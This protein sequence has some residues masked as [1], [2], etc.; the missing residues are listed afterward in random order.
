VSSSIATKLTVTTLAGVLLTAGLLV[1]IGSSVGRAALMDEATAALDGIRASRR[2]GIERYFR[3]LRE[4]VRTFARD[5]TLIDATLAFSAA[6]D[7]LASLA[8][9]PEDEISLAAFYQG[10]LK[11]RLNLS[12]QAW[13]GTDHYLPRTRAGRHLQRAYVSDNPEPVRFKAELLAA[14]GGTTYDRLHMRHHPRLRDLIESFGYYDLFLIDADGNLVYSVYK[15]TDFATNL[16]TGPY[17]ESNP[18]RLFRRIMQS[19][20]PGRVFIAD[21]EPYEPSYNQPAAFFGAPLFRNGLVVGAAILQAPAAEI[22]LIMGDAAGLGATGESFLVGSDLLLRSSSRFDREPSILVQ[23]VDTES[24]RRAV[25]G[26]S[27]HL[28]DA[29][30]RGNTVL[31]AYSPVEIEGLDWG[32]VTQIDMD[33]VTA[34]PDA[35]R[36]RLI[37]FGLFAALLV[38]V[39]SSGVLRRVVLEPVRRLAHAARSVE[40]GEYGHRIRR[41]ADDELGQ[42]GRVF[43]S[44]SSSIEQDRARLEDA[45][46]ELSEAR[47]EAECANRAKSAF[48]ANMSHELRTPMNA[49]LGY[50]EMVQEELAELDEIEDTGVLDDLRRVTDA[51]QHLLRLINDIL[52]LSKIE[53][54]RMDLYLER[55]D[56][57]AMIRE[58]ADTVRPLVTANDNELVVELDEDLGV[59]RIDLTKT[60]Q[61]LF[62]LISNAAKFTRGGTVTLTARR[63][64][65]EDADWFSL[66]VT[67]TGIGLAPD[68][69]EHVFDE[70]TQADSSTTRVYGGTGLGLPISRRFC[71]MMGG[72]ITVTSV[73]GEGSTFVIELPAQV[74]ALE[75]AKAAA[76]SPAEPAATTES[77]R[78]TGAATVLVVDDDADARELLRRALAQQGLEVLTAANGDEGL[79]LARERAP[80][81]ITLDVV[82]PGKDGWAV[83]RE[84]KADRTLGRIPVVMVSMVSE[85]G[86]GYMLGAADYLTKPVDKELLSHLIGRHLGGAGGDRVLVIEDD[87]PTRALVRRILEGHG[88][89]ITEAADGAA[90]LAA[91]QADGADLIVLDLMMPRMDGFEFLDRLRALDEGRGVPVVILTAKVL[92]AEEEN[93]LRAG[94]SGI[95]R[96][97]NHDM[98]ELLAAVQGQL[99]TTGRSGPG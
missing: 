77:A 15:E 71:R 35:L 75:A 39:I 90:G 80:D 30:Y 91:F 7:E 78:D 37:L 74:D 59:V 18:A 11:P 87:E 89:R 21:Y 48:L 34:G 84:L 55:V 3:F 9:D 53:A 43:N 58:S 72:D 67:D 76:S 29:G 50:T 47:D 63:T 6:F 12:G 95:I 52:D 1:G 92:T 38:A 82:M 14:R 46:R 19:P 86:L 8:P 97:G 88:C 17:R 40:A 73:E 31:A 28:E 54:G 61:A 64:R 70:F 49:I 85:K 4:Q 56:L 51:G 25:A 57:A 27:G 45:A 60:R 94:S 24:A 10:E 83:L 42:L 41:L 33:E 79:R 16:L 62:N 5:D 44:M 26:E 22:D 36:S 96:K 69:V 32:I 81:L 93:L 13:A 65:N 66:A 98:D 2:T 99:S 20:E 68:R 23:R